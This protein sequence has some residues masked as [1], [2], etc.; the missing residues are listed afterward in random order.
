MERMHKMMGT[1]CDASMKKD[2][3]DM[4]KHMKEMHSRMGKMMGGKD[5]MIQDDMG[6]KMDDNSDHELHHPKE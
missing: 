3:G 1:P 5:A 4:M 2:M 6:K